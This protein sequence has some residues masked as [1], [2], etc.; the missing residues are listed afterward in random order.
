MDAANAPGSEQG[1]PAS[2]GVIEVGSSMPVVFE[3]NEAIRKVVVAVHGIGDQF[4]YATIQSVVNQ[5]CLFY[6]Q[7]A[8]VPLGNFHSGQPGY[9]LS[10]PYPPKP[11]GSLA[12]A[13]VY[14]AKIARQVADEKHT[15]EEAKQWARTIVERLRLR[16]H[17]EGKWQKERKEA[18]RDEDFQLTQQVLDEMI[19]TIAVVERICFLAD[20]AGLFTFDLKKLLDDYLG[21]VQIVAEFKD[22]RSEIL[23]TFADLLRNLPKAFPNADIYFVAHSEGTVVTLLGLLEAFRQPDPPCWTRKVRGLMT[24]GSPIDKHLA[25]WPELFG[26]APPNSEAVLK[27]IEWR[28]YYDFGDPVGFKLDSIREWI[29]MHG[30]ERVFNFD[31]EK[32]DIGFTRYPFPGKAHVDYWTDQGVFRHFI[33]TVV[34]AVEKGEDDTSEEDRKEES[35][36]EPPVPQ[37]SG[38]AV[39]AQP[40]P[41][42]LPGP[43]LISYVLPYV[44]IF[45]LLFVASYVLYKA[46]TGAMDGSSPQSSSLIFRR[47]AGLAALLYGITVVARVPRLT[48]KTLERAVACAVAGLGALLYMWSMHDAAGT[49]I[50]DHPIPPGGV[51]LGLAILVALLAF[52]LSVNFP[53]WGMIPLML[54]G[55]V[56]VTAMVVHYVK[57]TGG[58]IWP[59]VL[60]T[61][62]FLYLWWLAALVFDLIFIWHLYIRNSKLLDRIDVI[63]GPYKDRARTVALHGGSSTLPAS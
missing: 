46:V 43:W 15:L 37:P 21:D 19:Q 10:H 11:F 16:W 62:A 28:N 4:S 47:S 30:W 14:W 44:G 50:Q 56:A 12:F 53:S 26:D 27:K 17:E 52:V 6:G 32:D 7:P 59:V 60:A 63:L 40:K 3:P 9:S 18:C 20:K 55:A 54:I 38:A 35:V 8:A 39:E 49:L 22:Y 13:E 58:P 5:F 25:L 34:E 31:G 41:R 33:S 48:R 2:G 51:T 24:L 23:K 42:S 29:G 61:V 45:A 57:D 1:H 36:T